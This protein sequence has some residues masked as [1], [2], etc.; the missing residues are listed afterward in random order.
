MWSSQKPLPRGPVDADLGRRIAL[1]LSLTMAHPPT[2][3]RP[4]PLL[5]ALDQTALDGVSVRIA[6]LTLELADIPHVAVKAPTPLPEAR[7]AFH[8]AGVVR[9]FVPEAGRDVLPPAKRVL[10]DRSLESVECVGYRAAGRGADEQM[11]VLRHHHPREELELVA[12]T[13]PREPLG[14]EVGNARAAEHGK[15]PL[16]RERDKP[17]PTLNLPPLHALADWVFGLGS[18]GH[19]H[20]LPA[21]AASPR[22][23]TTFRRAER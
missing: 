17:Q 3:A 23:A 15:P 9:P 22:E 10:R 5:G 13:R 20:S 14:E 6:N 18:I 16:A 21:A 8:S 2:H 11:N 12:A 4:P 1:D 19:V 7:T